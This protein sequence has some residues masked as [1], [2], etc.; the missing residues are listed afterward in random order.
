MRYEERIEP[1]PE[2]IA[3]GNVIIHR[4]PDGNF[5][6]AE[7][8]NISVLQWLDDMRLLS[9]ECIWAAHRYMACQHAYERRIQ[10]KGSFLDRS[11]GDGEGDPF[12]P[13]MADDYLKMVR[14]LT[15]DDTTIIDRVCQ[16]LFLVSDRRTLYD[17][18]VQFQELFDK[19]ASAVEAVSE[20]R[21]Q[22]NPCA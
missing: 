10:G 9:G 20:M 13:A 4:D 12:I 5:L 7:P 14:R 3:K 16:Q 1:T 18:R 15:R 19:L 22:N 21:M 6:S 2:M 17:Q 11:Q 8:S